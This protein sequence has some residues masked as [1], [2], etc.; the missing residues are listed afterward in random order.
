MSDDPKSSYSP[1][2]PS[3]L[4]EFIR[5][6]EKR[7]RPKLSITFLI[8]AGFSKSAGVPLAA[9]IIRELRDELNPLLNNAGDPP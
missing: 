7:G 5:H 4:G 9:E 8:G 1:F 3:E 6:S 2:T